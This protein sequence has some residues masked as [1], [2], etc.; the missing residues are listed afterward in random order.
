SLSE[1]R[2]GI[3]NFF[4][5]HW[6][7]FVALLSAWAAS[8]QEPSKE[9][10]FLK[11]YE[12]EWAVYSG[13]D[14]NSPPQGTTKYKM[15]IGGLWLVSDAELDFGGLKFIGHGLDSF[16]LAKKKYAGVW[17]DSQITGPI[18][19]EGELSADG[20]TLTCLGK[21]PGGQDGKVTDYKL[22]TEFKNKDLHVFKLWGGNLTGEP[23]LT[24]T[25]VRKK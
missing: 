22:V 24:L 6:F 21:G 7:S 5:K 9:H 2:T 10:Q 20:K 11:E 14:T 18:V 3:G 4:M 23:M 17:V 1:P 8:A 15:A 19:Y 16:D 12:G 25:Y 13:L